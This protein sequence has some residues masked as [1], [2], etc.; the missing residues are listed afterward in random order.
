MDALYTVTD[1]GSLDKYRKFNH[2]IN[3]CRKNANEWI[4]PGIVIII[5]IVLMTAVLKWKTVW[6]IAFILIFMPLLIEWRIR[7][8]YKSDPVLK[9]EFTFSF[10]SDR[11]EIV[12]ERWHTKLMYDRI[13]DIGESK[14]YFFIM[15]GRSTGNIISKEKCSE[16]LCE[17]IRGLKKD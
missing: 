11:M 12:G 10:F 15:A 9:R 1:S 8:A 5:T 14:E 16:E 3:F 13:Y 4:F 7:R 17:F 2:Y 6:Y